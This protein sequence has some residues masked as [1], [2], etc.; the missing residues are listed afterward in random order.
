M[1]EVR[2]WVVRTDAA[3]RE[4]LIVP[5]LRR[6][7]LRQGWGYSP[8][9]DLR[10]IRGRLAA[11]TALDDEERAAWSH[12]RRLLPDEDDSAKAG[13]WL[14]LPNLPQR[15]RWGLA[16]ANADYRFAI[17]ASGDHGHQRSVQLIREGLDPRGRHVAARLRRRAMWNADHLLGA[18]E[19]LAEEHD[20][21]ERLSM[22][23]AL[24]DVLGGAERGAWERIERHFGAAEL[25]GPIGLLL[26]SLYDSVE[27]RA[28]P[29]ERG[30]DFICRSVAPLGV[31]VAVAVQLKMWE[32]VATDPHPL[33]QLATA[34][35]AWPGLTGA[36]VI[37]TA[38]STSTSFD[39]EARARSR[40]SLAYRCA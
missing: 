30:A 12:N 17:A 38:E 3:V 32:G 34:A 10:R 25:E 35:S 31:Q 37:T 24:S 29:A 36:I 2:C 40:T 16:A 26:E 6:G 1:R 19:R 9:Q 13:D 11:G 20:A 23:D 5:E 28:G 22:L 15:G 39:A 8:S 7:V 33:R 4:D 14:L 18:V 21:G 27:R